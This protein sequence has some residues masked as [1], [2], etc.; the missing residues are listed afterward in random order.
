[1]RT[2][3][4]RL[5]NK[6]LE[7]YRDITDDVI[8]SDFVP[9]ACLFDPDTIL[10]KDGELLQIIKITGFTYEAINQE[11]ADLRNVIRDAISESIQSNDYALWFHT[12]RRKKR[13]SPDGVYPDEFS[14]TLHEHW[15][16]RNEWDRKFINELY[17]T[18][19]R[20][21][22]DADIK[23]VKGFFSGLL[24]WRDRRKRN[25]YLERSAAALD[26]T[27]VNMLAHLSEFG[28]K[29]LTIAERG[30]VFY[31]EHIEF[32]EKLINLEERPMPIGEQ[33]LSH[34]LT[35]GEISFAYNAMEVRTADEER[36]FGSIL[37][38]KEYKEASLY[39]IDEILQLP[40]EFIV[41]QCIDF[42][43]ARQALQTFKGQEYYMNVSG[44]TELAE[45]T[46]LTRILEN[47]SHREVDFGEQQTS[48][49]VI[50]ASV[51]EME[52]S[53][54]LIREAMSKIGIITIREDLRFEECYW[55]QLPANFE[56][57][58][59]L[60]YTNTEHVAG[61]VNIHNY[62]AGNARGCP[63]GPPVTLFYTAAGTPY[64][65]NFHLQQNGHTTVIG[66]FGSGKSVL[67][68]F[69]LS[70]SRKYHSRLFYLDARGNAGDF[71][72]AIGGNYYDLA[73]PKSTHHHLN[74]LG[75]PDQPANREF[76][77][78]WLSTLVDPLGHVAA[79]D[80]KMEWFHAVIAKMYEL[81]QQER[82][83][84]NAAAFLAEYDRMLADD[85]AQ[86][87]GEGD[88]AFYFDH[89]S[90]SVEPRN[91]IIGFNV[92][93][94]IDK[95]PILVPLA[96]YLLHRITMTLDGTPTILMLDEAWE[97]LNSPMFTPRVSAWMQYLT[98]RNALGIFTTEEVERI[99]E[100]KYSAGIIEQ[101]ATQIYLPDEEPDDVYQE[102]CGLTDEEFSYLDAMN[103]EYRHFMLKRVNESIIA[104]LNLGGLDEHLAV[105]SGTAS[106]DNNYYG[107][108][109]AVP[110][111]AR[112]SA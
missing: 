21:G 64:F 77:A 98:S 66:P 97:L 6:Q 32:L 63:W 91:N 29:R 35:S 49:F 110:F 22:E 54:R 8:E 27:V 56:F 40:C 87:Y 101:A 58:S 68:N 100:F 52:K 108:G 20:E 46:E 105:L 45:L 31:G 2:E 48:I 47:D 43:N 34:Y 37:T 24:P 9:Y 102:V 4:N 90:E 25:S 17:I 83:L 44:D 41:T 14:G 82:T 109:K 88:R 18:I 112:V 107:G 70:E 71:V 19:V 93:A 85:L 1:M 78:L 15:K 67:V 10:T 92:S 65:F 36:R 39:R 13:L 28:A 59:R 23:N 11:D 106:K 51:A 7:V 60:T 103:I 53:M 33:S 50:G 5:D 80:S 79:D 76:L 61:F 69:L 72:R 81:P 16:K 3:R 57:F 104:E 74:P 89:A 75:L 94:M 30:G 42:V 111:M 12:L 38:V 55:A 84:A 95:R 62:P 73:D 86:W 96:S 99:R 26:A